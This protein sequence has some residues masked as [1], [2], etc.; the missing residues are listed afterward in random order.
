MAASV[1]NKFE[2]IYS[3]NIIF[4]P[5]Y[6]IVQCFSSDGPEFKGENSFSLNNLYI[7]L[8]LTKPATT[9]KHI[10]VNVIYSC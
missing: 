7:P 3:I 5:A 2:H 1:L 6:V 8:K 9:A 4:T 10:L